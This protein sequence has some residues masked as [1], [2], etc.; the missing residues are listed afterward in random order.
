MKDKAK[1]KRYD[2]DGIDIIESY[3]DPE[4]ID[5]HEM[6]EWHPEYIKD[7]IGS[8]IDGGK[9]DDNFEFLRSTNNNIMFYR[10]KHF[11][12]TKDRKVY[13]F[14]FDPGQLSKKALQS[15]YK[16]IDQ[17]TDNLIMAKI[18]GKSEIK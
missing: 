17:E 2:K 7:F 6:M 13:H 9:I 12:I 5:L 16:L 18:L 11:S 8:K 15:L 10:P 3:S 1:N 4:Y 14:Y